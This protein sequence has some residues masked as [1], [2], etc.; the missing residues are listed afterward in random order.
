MACGA[1]SRNS[2]PSNKRIRPLAAPTSMKSFSGRWLCLP[3]FAATLLT[4]LSAP[5]QPSLEQ[6]PMNGESAGSVA[7][8]EGPPTAIESSGTAG[9]SPFGTKA[10]GPIFVLATVEGY[11]LDP[12]QIGTAI[13][14]ELNA[15]QSPSPEAARAT[16]TVRVTHDTLTVTYRGPDGHTLEREVRS[17]A[18]E[19]Q[20]PEVAALLSVNL[21]QDSSTDVLATLGS[22]AAPKDLPA[23]AS[24]PRAQPPKPTLQPASLP[25][26]LPPAPPLPFVLA[27]ATFVYPMVVVGDVERRTVGFELGVSYSQV[28][29]VDG[30]A[31]VPLV[32]H[33][34]QSGRGVLISGVGT[35]EGNS[36]YLT[37]NT[38]L[39]AAGLFNLGRGPVTGLS[40][41]GAADIELGTDA[42]G[43]GLV[44]GQVSGLVA[45]VKGNVEGAQISGGAAYAENV[46]GMQAGGLA[47][48]AIGRMEGVQV[49]GALNYSQAVEGAQVSGLVNVASGPITGAQ[50]GGAVNVASDVTGVQV[51]LVNVGKHVQGAQIGIVNVADEVDGASVGL[52]TYSK[53]G[54]TQIATWFD[55]T[56]PVNVGARFVSGALYA[57]PML[58][59]DPTKSDEFDFGF[60]LG[61]RLPLERFYF[62]LE[63]NSRNHLIDGKVDESAVD[64]RYRASVGIQLTPWLGFSAGGGVRHE[65][66]AK[67]GDPASLGG[68][69]TAGVDLL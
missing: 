53:K 18:N 28:G 45:I 17:P 32:L 21:S 23:V 54:R 43:P 66:N 29:A 30:A 11:T 36:E 51:A 61:A 7:P 35:I 6:P 58:A 41:A 44:G 63:C 33:V 56:R 10:L 19:S 8:T 4:A 49:G 25:V 37:P 24:A 57:M 12:A 38:G 16:F 52:I 5:A 26:N 69:W 3:A 59:A 13:A 67:N 46:V 34:R 20:I 55:S 39:R 65:F 47:S 14:Q 48:G 60:S 9:A 68:L 50:L 64:L 40:L 62:D 1:E 42:G 22:A 2:L 27:N 31:I 15:A